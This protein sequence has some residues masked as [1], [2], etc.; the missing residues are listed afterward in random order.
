M[1]ALPRE[2]M[3]AI[4]LT[5]VVAAVTGLL[6]PF[7]V[8]GVSQLVFPYQSNGSLVKQNG[9][10][11][12]STLI[13][14]SFTSTRYFNGRVSATTPTPYD[15][16][17]SGGS[18]LAPSNAALQQRVKQDVARI[19]KQDGL[20]PNAP[21]PVDLVT[22]SFSGLD[23]DVSEAAALIQVNR[24]AQARGLQPSKVR[25]LVEQNVQG[26]VLGLFGDPYV[27]VLQLNQALDAGQAR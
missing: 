18:N 20:G 23:P 14:Q 21:I 7:F 25:A 2:V 5:L 6:Y 9:Q 12:G 15:A 26:R 11:V 16:S 24:I 17:A 19:R 4:R 13:G 8:T 10:V 1:K 27:N 3:V 22:S